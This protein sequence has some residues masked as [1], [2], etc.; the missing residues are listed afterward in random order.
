MYLSH[1]NLQ[2]KP[3]KVSTDPKF[4]WLGEKHKEALDTLRYGILHS[5]GY[6]VLTGDVG[7][8]KTTLAMTLAE[9]L[10][11]KV[12]VARIPFPDVEVLDFLKLISTAFGINS[13]V[14]SKASF[15][16]R[17]ESFLHSRFSAGKRAVL[18]LDEA[19]RMRHEHLEELL[20]LSSAEEEGV[21]LLNIVFVGQNEFNEILQEDSNRALR[22]RIAIN[23]NLIPLTRA[24]TEQYISHRLNVAHCQREI[25][26]SEAIQDIFLY[27][28]GIPR[29]INIVCDLALLMT[30]LEGGEVVQ[31]GAVKQALE[32]LRL[33]GERPEFMVTGPRHSP[34]GEDKIRDE[35]PVKTGGEIHQE[36]MSEET[37]K[38]TH[39]KFLWAAGLALV[40]MLVG[41][42]LL[43]GREGNPPQDRKVET[44]GQKSS[45][46][47]TESQVEIEPSKEQE[48]G[49]AGVLSLTEVPVVKEADKGLDPSVQKKAPAGAGKIIPPKKDSAQGTRSKSQKVLDSKVSGGPPRKASADSL[50]DTRA[51]PEKEKDLGESG[52]RSPGPTTDSSVRETSERE[53][54]EAEPGKAIDWLLEKRD[55]K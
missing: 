29:L 26:T 51:R 40:A 33:P 7:T 38:T 48:A 18:I 6:V 41:L 35:L 21:G 42:A 28:N 24:E 54:E 5:D 19:Q 25:F 13:D 47:G 8:G 14:Q 52:N 34:A 46:E 3:F 15:R 36:V 12:I 22:Q 2:E 10:S 31:P 20:Q 23:Y 37:R 4:L 27:S 45:R 53:T 30:Y 44:L 43:L 9:D 49:G 11:D 32:R 17:F 16:D 55:R 50:P 39:A 1:F